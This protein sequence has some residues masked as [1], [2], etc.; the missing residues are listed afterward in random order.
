MENSEKMVE[1]ARFTYARDAQAL[2]S[3]LKSE[4]IDC[5]I[6]NEIITQFFSGLM[7]V[8]GAIVELL[9]SDVPH[10]LEVM[11]EFGYELPDENQQPDQIQVV[12]NITRNIPFLRKLSLENQILLFFILIAVLLAAFIFAYPLL[13]SK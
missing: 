4:G 13:T 8:G 3:L 6:R 11:E 5:Y 9:E 7:D 2:V 10:A 12:S 1:I